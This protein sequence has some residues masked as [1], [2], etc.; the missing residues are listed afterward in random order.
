M[1]N[2]RSWHLRYVAGNPAMFSRVTTAAGGPFRRREAVNDAQ[3]ILDFS[4][5]WR[6]WV[7]RD[8]G[9]RAFESPAE[10]EHRQASEAKRIIEFATANVP[11]SSG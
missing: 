10:M 4:P 11:G 9:T 7:E 3:R 8:D 1:A 2:Q 5:S 6:I